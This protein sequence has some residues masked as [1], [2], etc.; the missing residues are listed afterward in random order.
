[1]L[2][3]HGG[4]NHI[5]S[6]VWSI[7]CFYVTCVAMSQQMSALIAKINAPT[8]H[9]FLNTPALQFSA[10]STI[11]SFFF[12]LAGYLFKDRASTTSYTLHCNCEHLAHMAWQLGAVLCIIF[13]TTSRHCFDHIDFSTPCLHSVLSVT[14]SSNLSKRLLLL[15]AWNIAWHT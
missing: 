7:Y 13:P 4:A 14:C 9:R 10:W 3:S 8:L 6:V 11:E 15:K 5:G 2:N 12:A 1:M